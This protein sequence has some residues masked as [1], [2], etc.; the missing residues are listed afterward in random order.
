MDTEA[1]AALLI[2]AE[3]EQEG[4]RIVDEA[5]ARGVTL[6]LAGGLAVRLHCA[7]LDFC[8]RD[9][10]DLDMVGLHREV[11]DLIAVFSGLGY[12]EE[13]DV[14]LATQ[15][16]QARFVR[17]CVH[18]DSGG[19]ATHE[20]DHV[21]VF[22]DVISMDHKIHLDG[23]LWVEPYTIPLTELLLTKLQ[24]HRF[25]DKDRQDVLTILGER[26]VAEDDGP[27][28]VNAAALAER[29]A[30]DWGL[31]Y[32]VVF[33]LQAVGEDLGDS[34]LGEAEVD[35][36]R[37]ALTRLVDAIQAAPKSLAWRVR[38]KVGTK[39]RWYSVVEEQ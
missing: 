30:S 34:G 18:R 27:G 7:A 31:F 24:I 13:F 38:A 4:K 33:N 37:A 29:C 3:M 26:E 35:H 22:L 17:P 39:R 32:D 6:R 23:R 2:R 9:Y 36:A 25:T 28:V 11:D 21:D 10:S 12:Q 15:S 1:G 20:D 14:R 19:L 5:R 16:R 8:A